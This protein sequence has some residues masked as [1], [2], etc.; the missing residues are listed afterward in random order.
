MRPEPGYL[1]LT[2]AF[3]LV[4]FFTAY[5][6]L[7]FL[8]HTTHSLNPHNTGKMS[9]IADGTGDGPTPL[10]RVLIALH[11]GFDTLDVAGPVE[12]MGLARHDFKDECKTSPTPVA[13]LLTRC[14]SSYQGLPNR[15][16]LRHR[17]H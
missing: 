3:M 10:I 6:D 2:E 9:A 13:I 14:L 7:L 8:Q 16:R 17:V 1:S 11:P 15:I 5:F 4:F 12:V